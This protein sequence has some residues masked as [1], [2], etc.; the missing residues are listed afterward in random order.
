[1]PSKQKWTSCAWSF[2]V[3]KVA[4]D[5]TRLAKQKRTQLILDSWSIKDCKVSVHQTFWEKKKNKKTS[6]L[7]LTKELIAINS[8]EAEEKGKVK[9]DTHLKCGNYSVD[10]KMTSQSCVQGKEP[11]GDIGL[12][13]SPSV[14]RNKCFV[15]KEEKMINP[16]DW[17]LSFI[18]PLPAFTAWTLI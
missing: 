3:F 9:Q 6:H 7:K 2:E 10:P 4:V 13:F 8:D 11:R 18:L 1:M 17:A 16:K 14:S 12:F 5:L 15:R